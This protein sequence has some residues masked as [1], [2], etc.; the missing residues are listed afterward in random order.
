MKSRRPDAGAAG[1]SYAGHAGFRL[2]I[3]LNRCLLIFNSGA[4]SLSLCDDVPLTCLQPIP[5]TT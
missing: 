2:L 3:A 5:P 1:I 4:A